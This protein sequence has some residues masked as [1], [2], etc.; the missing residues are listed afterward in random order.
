[1]DALVLET[2]NRKLSRQLMQSILDFFSSQTGSEVGY[3]SYEMVGLMAKV[4]E[5]RN[6][7]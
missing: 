6:L 7:H 4:S 5:D 1:M 2:R 3:G